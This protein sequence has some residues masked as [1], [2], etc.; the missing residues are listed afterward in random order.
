MTKSQHKKYLARL[1]NLRR[2]EQ[3]AYK[4]DAELFPKAKTRAQ[5]SWYGRSSR[6]S[7]TALL[8]GIALC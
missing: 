3:L 2:A 8:A 7:R 5:H 1:F 4:M 6:L